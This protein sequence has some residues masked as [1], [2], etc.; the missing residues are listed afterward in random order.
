MQCLIHII[1]AS[2]A[3][4]VAAIFI[5]RS[6]KQQHIISGLIDIVKT[7][8]KTIIDSYETPKAPTEKGDPA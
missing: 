1:I 8:Q 7:Q 2:M 5:N 6:R 4:T 3:I